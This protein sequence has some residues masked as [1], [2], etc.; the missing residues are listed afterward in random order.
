MN[1]T[2]KNFT[3]VVTLVI[4]VM[5][6]FAAGLWGAFMFSPGAYSSSPRGIDWVP[7]ILCLTV[8]VGL[9]RKTYKLTAPWSKEIHWSLTSLL[10]VMLLFFIWAGTPLS[11]CRYFPMSP[12][13]CDMV[14]GA[15]LDAQ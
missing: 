2:M 12:A 15:L 6:I 10:V 7:L 14:G 5:A 1:G 4:A 13:K 3:A 11:S 9:F 8:G